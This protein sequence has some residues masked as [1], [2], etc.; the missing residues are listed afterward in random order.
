MPI[1]IDIALS[2]GGRFKPVSSRTFNEALV[3]IGRDED[4]TLTLEDTH[5][6]VSRV[7]AELAEEDG[8]YWMKVV[9]KVNPV[10]VNGKRL[11][12]GNRVALADGDTLAIGLYRLEVHA[13]AAAKPAANNEDEMTFVAGRPPAPPGPPATAARPAPAIPAEAEEATYV[14]PPKAP[15]PAAPA[16]APAAKAAVPREEEEATFVPKPSPDDATNPS[17]RVPAP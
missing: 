11:M 17:A 7:H 9:S 12:S 2:S 1:K 10:I 4:C 6:H 5:K 3:T 16:A 15:S 14:P 13:A 8:V